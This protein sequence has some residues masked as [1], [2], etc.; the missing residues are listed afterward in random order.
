MP[1]LPLSNDVT[2]PADRCPRCDDQAIVQ[3]R[4]IFEAEEDPIWIALGWDEDSDCDTVPVGTQI[5]FCPFCGVK[6]P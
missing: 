1:T 5:D 6:L 2:G 4:S 3:G